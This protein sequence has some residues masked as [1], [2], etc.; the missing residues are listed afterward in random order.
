MAVD[1]PSFARG[2]TWPITITIAAIMRTRGYDAALLIVIGAGLFV[3]S[4]S[5]LWDQLRGDMN[6]QTALTVLGPVSLAVWFGILAGAVYDQHN[7]LPWYQ[8]YYNH[9]GPLLYSVEGIL[10]Y[11]FVYNLWSF[12]HTC[13]IV[14]A[15]THNIPQSFMLVANGPY[16]FFVPNLISRRRF[17]LRDIV[18]A[19]RCTVVNAVAALCAGLAVYYADVV[20]KFVMENDDIDMLHTTY[21]SSWNKTKCNLNDDSVTSVDEALYSEV[22]F[23]KQC[24]VMVWSRNRTNLLVWMQTSI[25]FSLLVNIPYNA[26]KIHSSHRAWYVL[27]MVASNIAFALAVITT[28]DMLTAWYDITTTGA[29]LFSMYGGTR[30]IANILLHMHTCVDEY[31][32]NGSVRGYADDVK[33]KL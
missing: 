22:K 15:L 29:I 18:Y 23:V 21:Y 17:A 19:R 16:V 2:S 10:I 32:E 13:K 24:A 6:V 5:C 3:Y 33:L 26:R 1:I 25:V 31:D 12:C 27:T 8:A 14:K 7:N 4:I 30:L 9:R 11:I 20:I 28:L